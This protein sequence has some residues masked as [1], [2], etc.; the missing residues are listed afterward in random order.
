MAKKKK[1]KRK[2]KLIAYSQPLEPDEF[3]TLTIFDKN[4][5]RGLPIEH[6]IFQC[7]ILTKYSLHIKELINGKK[8]KI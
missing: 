3:S 4:D 5:D 6:P 7:T 1:R 8:N 2:I